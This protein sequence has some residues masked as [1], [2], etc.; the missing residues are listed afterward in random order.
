[1]ATP[2]RVTGNGSAHQRALEA[3]KRYAKRAELKR[4]ASGPL[5]ALSPASAK[6]LAKQLDEAAA[7][8]A[9]WAERLS[10]AQANLQTIKDQA[11]ELSTELD[12]AKGRIRALETIMQNEGI[13]VPSDPPNT[14][15]SKATWLRRAHGSFGSG[16][17]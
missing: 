5:V 14:D 9:Y 7:L 11:A 15:D 1:M 3:I 4:S 10:L 17:R 13:E 12:T 2:K 6:R 8:D 16:H